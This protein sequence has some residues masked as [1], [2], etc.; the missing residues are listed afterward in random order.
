[1]KDPNER[2]VDFQGDLLISR[3]DEDHLVLR[4]TVFDLAKIVKSARLFNVPYAGH[5]A[6]IDQ[7]E[8]FARIVNQFLV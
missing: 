3:G 5:A 1:M 8:E 2:L 7:P 6:H 4:E